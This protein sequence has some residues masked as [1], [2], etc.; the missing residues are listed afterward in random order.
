VTLERS[1]NPAMATFQVDDVAPAATGLPTRRLAD[2]WRD[3]LALGGDPATPVID[4]G[5]THPLLAAVGIAFAQHRPLI[6]SPDAVWL[7]I[8]QG[9]AQHVRLHARALRPRLVR[10]AGRKPLVVPWDGD[11]PTCPAAWTAI[12]TQFRGRLADE[13]GDGMAALFQCDFSTSTEVERVASQ[14]VLLDAYSPFFS[15][16]M[17]C[18]CG[19]PSITLTGTVA[20]WQSIR[21]RIDVIAELDLATW[22]RSLAPIADQFVRAAAGDLD[23]AFWRRIYNPGDAYG[24][25]VITGWITRLYPYIEV[26][27]VV[28]HPNPM[29]ALPIDEPR[30]FPSGKHYDGPGL[31]SSAVPATRSRVRVHVVDG[32][33]APRGV[34]LEAGVVAV[35]QEPDLA[36]R[37]MIAWRLAPAEAEIEDVVDRI[38]ADPRT[39][40]VK[41]AGEHRDLEG[42][43]E[44]IALYQRIDT[45]TLFESPRTWRIR[46]PGEHLQL[47][48]KAGDPIFCL[49]DVP[50][51]RSIGYRFPLRSGEIR[52][53]LC[54]IREPSS[55]ATRSGIAALQPI[56]KSAMID[57]GDSLTAILDAAL[58]ADGAI[59]DRGVIAPDAHPRSPAR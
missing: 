32:A 7:T 39:V 49:I 22:C 36:L 30:G 37:P 20:D 40:V 41:P 26:D 45:A 57:L 48:M 50:D 16:W 21:E 14:I 9:V 17:R 27:G 46:A 59:D 8:A 29:L 47:R 35:A 25:E 42:P 52:W 38:L 13:I 1:Y 33:G 58:D 18:I 19:I 6:L 34:A 10:H 56:S 55:G 28:N 43:A 3:T 23:L 53:Y 54:T 51:G 31:R 15:Y 24:G 12:V 44:L 11:L 4:H 5:K 2:L